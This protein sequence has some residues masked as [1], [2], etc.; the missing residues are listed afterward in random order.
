MTEVKQRLKYCIVATWEDGTQFVF[1]PLAMSDTADSLTNL[2][3]KNMSGVE[4]RSV[5]MLPPDELIKDI[6][7]IVEEN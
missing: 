6:E 1:G 5:A 3:S 4:F 2:A 7:Q